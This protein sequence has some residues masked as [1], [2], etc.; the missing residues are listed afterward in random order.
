MTDTELRPQADPRNKEAQCWI[1]TA[2][3]WLGWLMVPLLMPVYA[4]LFAFTLSVL[5]FTST[6]AKVNLTL[7]V[8]GINTALP[9]LL[10]LLLKFF[11]IVKDPGLNSRTE[12][13]IP[14]AISIVAFGLTAWFLASRGA[15][16]WF[17]MFFAGGAVA[18]LVNLAI[19]FRWKISAHA[20]GAAGV[21]ALLVRIAHEGL[22]IAGAFTWLVIWTALTGLLG[23]A[24]IYQD[25]HTLAQVLAGYAVG[26]AG[27]YLMMMIH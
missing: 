16:I 10:I 13:F 12:R 4:M 26:F 24:R 6:A 27:V 2:A 22:P 25:R 23:S 11:G 17:V 9:M 7:I 21:L 15:P 5:S 14:Y 18:G 8:A 3:H 20:A 1:D 19:N